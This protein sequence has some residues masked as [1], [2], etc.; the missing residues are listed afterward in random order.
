MALLLTGGREQSMVRSIKKF[1]H[2]I[3]PHHRVQLQ[4]QE[5]RTSQHGMTPNRF[6]QLKVVLFVIRTC[7]PFNVVEQ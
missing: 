2:K 6:H 1:A 4:K 3:H 5:A 7:Q